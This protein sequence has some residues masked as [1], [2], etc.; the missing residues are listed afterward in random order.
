MAALRYAAA[1]SGRCTSNARLHMP[2]SGILDEIVLV[3]LA[4]ILSACAL[5]KADEND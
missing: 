4:V 5:W 1:S 2:A 3:D